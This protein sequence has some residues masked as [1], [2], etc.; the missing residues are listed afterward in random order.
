MPV[1]DG[2][3]ATKILSEMIGDEE[4]EEFF[5]I[6]ATANKVDEKLKL[7]CQMLGMIDMINKPIFR[8]ELKTILRNYYF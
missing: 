7:D 2:Y 3:E 1:M 6:G 4:I 8:K 5:I